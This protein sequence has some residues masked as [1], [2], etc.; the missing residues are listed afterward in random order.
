MGLKRTLVNR[1]FHYN[2]GLNHKNFYNVDCVAVFPEIGVCFNRI[3]KAGNTSVCAYLADICGYGDF[4]SSTALKKRLLKPADMSFREHWDMRSYRTLVVVRD[5]YVRALSAFLDKVAPGCQKQFFNYP[6]FGDPSPDGFERFLQRLKRSMGTAN[7]HFWP[8]A[9][10]LFQPLER[11]S[12]VAH[13][14]TLTQDLG[15]FLASIGVDS[16]CRSFD[17]P[18]D[19]ERLE[20][21]KVT[22]SARFLDNYYRAGSLKLVQELYR[23]DFDLFGYSIDTGILKA[24]YDLTG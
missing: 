10:L 11:F 16:S 9:D 24:P 1:I 8:Q 4:S 23:K 18:H 5:P 22:K 20:P 13:L 15:K 3:K 19:L 2:S 17:R 7:R 6:G 21:G 14:E 12:C